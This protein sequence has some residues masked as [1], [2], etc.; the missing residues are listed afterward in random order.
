MGV[1]RMRACEI[2]AAEYQP[3]YGDQRTC[4]RTCGVKLKNRQRLAK[5]IS[6]KVH[7]RNC[8][9]CGS[10][11]VTTSSRQKFCSAACSRKRQ[12]A[13]VLDRHYG[14]KQTG[15][16]GHTLIAYLAQRDHGRCGLCR[17]RVTE[18]CGELGPSVDHVVPRSLGGSDDL[19][20][21]QL[22]H[23]RCNR[24][25]GNRGGGEQLALVG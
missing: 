8:D 24:S 18:A 14:F 23:L 20:N 16:P 9:E 19:A 12:I 7:Q 22:A 6:P 3:T 10:P 15:M 21:L 13:R 11:F 2:C 25:K 1:R 4:G 17:Q 5:P